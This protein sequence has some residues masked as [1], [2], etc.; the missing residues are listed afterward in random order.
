MKSVSISTILLLVLFG[1]SQIFSQWQSKLP[2][3]N[4]SLNAADRKYNLKEISKA[5]NDY[6]AGKDIKGG[7][8]FENGERKKATGWKQF[9]REEWFWEQRVNPLTGE[10]PSTTSSIEFERSSSRLRKSSGI[11]SNANWTNLG[12]NS[13]DGGYAGIGRVNC[14]AFHPTDVNTFWVGAPSGGIWKTADG[15]SS[16]TC[17][18]NTM[19]TLGVSNIAIPSDFAISN[20]IYIT[21]GD[22]DGGSLWTLGS[23]MAADNN[24]IGV[25][26]STDGGSSWNATGLNYL[27]SASKLVYRLLVHPTNTQILLAAT[28]NG[29]YKSTDGG[30]TWTQKNANKLVDMEFKPGD[31]TIVYASSLNFGDGYIFRS[32][33]TGDSWSFSKIATGGR[34][35][36]IAVTPDDPAVVYLLAANDKGGVLDVFKSTNSGTSFSKINNNSATQPGMLG[37]YTDAAGDSTGQGSYDWCIAA[38]PSDANVV[39]IGGITT[40]KSVDGG[41][42]W[43]AINNWT[44]S[45]VY[46]KSHVA[47]VHADKHALEFQNSSTLYEGNDGGVYKT[48]DGGTTWTDLSDGLV[49]SQLYRLGLS[50]TNS[51]LV[52]TGLQDNGTKLYSSGTWSDVKGGDG[53]ECIIDHTDPTYM[54]ATYIEGQISR[55]VNTGVSFPTDISANIPGGKPDG[56]WVTPYIID[57]TN[58]Q[59]L[60]AGYDQIWKTT[61]RGNTWAS[62]SSVLSATDKLRAIAIAPTATDVIYTSDKTHIWKTIDATVVSPTWTDI[63]GT[64]PVATSSIT[65]LAIKANDP[66]TVWVTFGGFASG[67]KIFETTDGGTTWTNISGALPNLP[68]MSVVQN[69]RNSASHLFIGTDVGVYEKMPGQDWA[70]F[71]SGLPNVVVTE[72]EIFYGAS[73]SQDRLRAATFGRG[74]WETPLESTAAKFIVTS[75][76]YSPVAGSAITITAQLAD[77]SNNPVLE[78]GRTVTWSKSNVNG[79]FSSV[80]SLTNASGIA[81]VTFTTHTLASTNATVTGNDGIVNGTSPVITTVAGAAS[82]YIVTSSSYNPNAGNNVTL[83]AQLAD[84]NNNPVS[85]SGLTVTWSKSDANGAFSNASSITNASGIATITLTTHTISGTVTTVTANDGTLSGTSSTITTVAGAATKYIVTSS[86]YS[87][88]A[89]SAVSIT[90]QLADVNNNPV[91]TSGV[92]VNWTKSDANGAFSSATS[93]I[94]ASGIAT[95]TY[96]THTI[97]GTATTVTA[98]DGTLSG[99]S[100]TI[101]TTGGV[102]NPIVIT[103]LN[104]ANNSTGV[105]LAPLFSWSGSGSGVPVYAITIASD[106]LFTNVNYGP[107]TVSSPYQLPDINA[108]SNSTIYYWRITATLPGPVVSSVKSKFST[109]QSTA[110]LL[111]SP[112]QGSPIIGSLINFVWTLPVAGLQYSVELD[113]DANFSSQIPG[114]PTA[115]SSS[116]Y[117]GFSYN[118]SILAAGTYYWRVK[119]C[120][121]SGVLVSISSAGRFTISGPPTAIPSYP[122]NLATVY[123]SSPT[124]YW[125]LNNYLY[126]GTVYYRIRYGTSSGVYSNTTTFTT[127]NYFTLSDLTIGSNY[128]YVIDA[129]S[130]PD[131]VSFNTSVEGDFVVFYSSVSNIPIYK[132]YPAYWI[133]VYTLSPTL[134]WY[135]GLYIPG[136]MFDVQVDNSSNVFPSPEINVTNIPSYYFTTDALTAGTT[137]WWRVRISGSSTWTGYESFT[138]HPN[139]ASYLYYP[140]AVIPR[141]DSHA[142]GSVVENQNFS[143]SWLANS[144]SQLEYKVIYSSDPTLNNGVLQNTTTTKGGSSAWL[145][146]NNYQLSGLSPGVTYYW[147]VRSRLAS[148]Q[149]AVSNYSAVGQFTVSPGSAP[150]V[151]LPI[152]PIVGSTINS[153]AANLSWIIPAKSSSTLVYDL[154]LSKNKDMTSAMLISNLDQS[155]YKVTNLLSNQRYYWRVRSKTNTGLISDYSYK[156]EF[157]TG[158]ATDGGEKLLLP[159]QFELA[160]NYPNPFNPS[161]VISFSITQNSFV[162]LKVF[163]ILGREV[164]TLVGKEM[165]AGNYSVNWEGDDNIGNLVTTGTY[166]YRITAGNFVSSKKM[167]LVK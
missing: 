47:V 73:Q 142:G 69:V 20:T 103:L 94:N 17:V 151:A 91:L 83:T 119:A 117:F 139:A 48:I 120:N 157:N 115:Q 22:R 136:V 56:A 16:W 14:I 87:P 11:I 27:S 59:T 1:A 128:Y 106:S 29:I 30:T 68:V 121:S 70:L 77:A 5:F 158:S 79:S 8:Y 62:I 52:I 75:S 35:C 90:A 28:T 165:S 135:L 100:S 153:N 161:T 95:V 39:Y 80:N 67:N 98:N 19:A 15:G 66:N 167:I 156:G 42:T 58:S 130:S 57:P 23:G 2:G 116:N 92:T 6:W 166:I 21:T 113:N 71:N 18:N 63:T 43:T 124:I 44:S 122:I 114:F 148:D 76:N 134:Y 36:E 10:F 3:N 132:S 143:V 159:T 108:L 96:T 164:K 9:K 129:S 112:A 13:S 97:G 131:F 138:I 55:S 82:K 145:T 60:Y 105:S 74:L 34:R 88:V 149:N 109:I 4:A 45:N 127:Y 89:G 141:L 150:T 118:S 12:T 24:S 163:D 160:Q 154:E 78:S 38:S 133:Y 53:M 144:S 32:T 49:I 33:N 102:V 31:P 155:N 72:L 152:N 84:I 85:T 104:P 86:N 107:V 101:T 125:Y 25:Y 50:K 140:S 65:Y 126:N 93:V 54:Y 40:W 147:Q 123:T 111:V 51:N 61:D 41:V 81:T 146:P 7:Y 137:Y 99:T 64:L 162:S 26:K 37:Y 46:N 110:P